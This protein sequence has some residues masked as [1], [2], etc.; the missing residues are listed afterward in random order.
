[1]P[2]SLRPIALPYAGLYDPL[3]QVLRCG[4]NAGFFSNCTVTLWHLA[5]LHRQHGVLPARLDFSAA[6]SS[7]RNPTQLREESDLYPLFFRPVPAPNAAVACATTTLPMVR[8]HGLYR[9]ID[10]ARL[11]PVIA[12]YFQPSAAA[13]DLAHHLQRKYG[14]D[15][16]KTIAVVYRGTDK[17]IEVQLADPQAYLRAT[18]AL[19]AR[20]PDH[21]VLI[22]TDEWAVQQLFLQ[23]LG[24]R[25]F[26]LDEMP[27]SRDGMVVHCLDDQ[28]LRMDRS[29]F[30]VLLVAVTHLLSQ[31]AFIVNHTGNMALW[32]ALYRGHARGL[33][34]FD[35]GGVLVRPYH[36]VYLLR[37][38]W[39]LARKARQRLGLRLA[40][41]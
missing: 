35:E 4:H 13:Q 18:Q 39:Q 15:L 8:H 9:F 10:F 27:V 17:G 34:Q 33:L 20:H 3:T 5:Q 25:C 14:I 41:A 11:N 36:P 23:T 6:F 24:E 22:Q 37:R 19:L 2:D 26:A 12:A 32:I 29:Q 28:A 40:P 1:M 16:H 7:Y 30:G 21:R 38:A 31:A